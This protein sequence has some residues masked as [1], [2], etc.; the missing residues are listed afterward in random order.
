MTNQAAQTLRLTP[1]QRSALECAGL[2]IL[3]ALTDAERVLIAALDG[4]RLTVTAE[5]RDALYTALNDRSNAEDADA[6]QNTDA[7]LRAYA[8]RASRSLAALASR[9]LR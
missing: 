9:V 3:D 1:T 7:A 5:T 6:E 8:R 4:Y 2:D